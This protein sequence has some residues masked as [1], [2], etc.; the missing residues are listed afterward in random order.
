MATERPAITLLGGGPVGL[1]AAL[2]LADIANIRV[3]ESGQAGASARQPDGSPLDNRVYALSPAS[4][5][6]L[7]S[8]CAWS[9]LRAERVA[10]VDAMQVFGDASPGELMLDARQPLAWIVEHREL[11]AALAEVVAERGIDVCHNAQATAWTPSDTQSGQST[12]LQ[13][14]GTA[15]QQSLIIGADGAQSWLRRAAGLPVTHKSYESLGVVAN[16]ACTAP[17]Q[18][19]ARQWFRGDSVLAWLPLPGSAVSIVWSVTEAE[20]KRL[21]ALSPEA[22]AAEVQA[23]GHSTLG[24]MTPISPVAA[25]PLRQTLAPAAVAEGLVLLGDAAHAIHPLAGQGVNL[26]FGDVAALRSILSGRGPL[27]R[28]GARAL[29]RRYERARREDV[30]AMALITDQLKALFEQSTRPLPAL[31]NAGLAWVDRQRWLKH[32]IIRRAMG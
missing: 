12:L 23:A 30:A 10:R 4:R 31:R 20:G 13:A 16:F 28:V 7:T 21:M 11:V 6:L 15:L 26:G 3:V 19:V 8:L 14:D 2:A 24:T 25:F 32:A 27:Q 9:R 22:L 17:H 29:L 1:A 18:A 5:D